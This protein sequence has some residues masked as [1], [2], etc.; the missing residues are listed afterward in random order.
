MRGLG[1]EFDLCELAL[2]DL[3]RTVDEALG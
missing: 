2:K 3:A 1:Q